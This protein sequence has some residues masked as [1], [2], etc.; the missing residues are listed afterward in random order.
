MRFRCN[1]T[2]ST[3]NMLPSQKF[4]H[5]LRVVGSTVTQEVDKLKQEVA[6]GQSTAMGTMHAMTFLDNAQKEVES[7]SCSQLITA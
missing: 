6:T 2:S 4:F 3:L 5:D 1:L 7:H